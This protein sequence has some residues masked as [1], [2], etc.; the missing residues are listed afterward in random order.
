MTPNHDP[1][2]G[3]SAVRC[4]RRRAFTL[5]ELLTVMGILLLMS[6][7]T[8]VA[9]GRVA[10]DARISSGT[11][12][13]TAALGA[14]R[15]LAMERNSVILVTFAPV[16][17]PAR[18]DLPQLT[19]VVIAEPTG[20]ADLFFTGGIPNIASAFRPVRGY[21]PRTLPQ[22]VGVAGPQ[23][24]F[25]GGDTFWITLPDLRNQERGRMLA[26]LFSPDGRVLTR[27]PNGSVQGRH[28]VFLDRNGNG[29]QDISFAGSDSFFI[30]AIG[31]EP[32][33][34]TVNTIAIFDDRE[35][36]RRYDT[37]LWRG[38]S[39]PAQTERLEKITEYITE[40]SNRISFNRYS[41]VVQ[42]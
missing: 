4:P 5:V 13:V 20:A 12:A 36:R 15:G 39:V 26:I 23:S 18:P 34:Q 28:Y 33:L 35:L 42:R 10:Q 37:T 3:A 21:Q 41:G 14:A 7:L 16:W 24:D 22:G 32:N 8:A 25:A 27:M 29:V 17:D 9:V 11:N 31:D 30:G 6:V 2:R 38:T 40:S 19:E 1:H